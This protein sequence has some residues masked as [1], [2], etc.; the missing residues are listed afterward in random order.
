M[1]DTDAKVDE[2]VATIWTYGIDKL[3][4]TN[5]ADRDHWLRT[6]E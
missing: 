2:A 4:I 6:A 3:S 1:Y 5:I